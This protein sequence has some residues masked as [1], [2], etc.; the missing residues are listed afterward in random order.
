MLICFA[1][2]AHHNERDGYW[3]R[4]VTVR[5]ENG[6]IKT[7]FNELSWSLAPRLATQLCERYGIVDQAALLCGRIFSV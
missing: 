7:R 6:E 2:Q 5:R 3:Y 4:C 1:F